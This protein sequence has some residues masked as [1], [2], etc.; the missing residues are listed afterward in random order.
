MGRTWLG[1]VGTGIWLGLA[2]LGLGPRMALL[3]NF[4]ELSCL[5]LGSLLVRPILDLEQ[6]RCL[7]RLCARL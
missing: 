1:R 2:R 5:G 6:L 4:L 3:G 7:R